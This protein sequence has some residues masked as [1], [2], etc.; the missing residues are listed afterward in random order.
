MLKFIPLVTVLLL[1]KGCVIPTCACL[2]DPETEEDTTALASTG[3]R[4]RMHKF[5][6]AQDAEL[7]PRKTQDQLLEKESQ[8]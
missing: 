8:L 6:Q 1:L 7:P 4:M 2:P 3:E 5:F